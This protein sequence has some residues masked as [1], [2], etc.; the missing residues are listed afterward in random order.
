MPTLP[1]RLALTSVLAAILSFKDLASAAQITVTMKDDVVADDGRCSLREAIDAANL[2]APSGR[3]PGECV[4]G[5][6][7]PTVDVIQLRRGIYRLK[8]GAAGDDGNVGGDL[9]VT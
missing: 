2:D 1:I 7:S 9:D 8:R 5:D 4:A 6:R 3:T